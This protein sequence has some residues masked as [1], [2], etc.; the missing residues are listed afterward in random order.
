LCAW[1]DG[2]LV[3]GPFQPTSNFHKNYCTGCG[4]RTFYKISVDA[5]FLDGQVDRFFGVFVGDAYGKQYYFGISPWQFYFIGQHSNEGDSWDVIDAQWSGAVNA[6]Y[7]TNNFEVKVQPAFKQNTADYVFSLNGSVV[8]IIYAKPVVPS[9]T[10]LAMD[11]HAVTASYDNWT[12]E[13]IER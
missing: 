12:Y 3:M 8:Y 10:G 11:W 1:K 7:A 9:Q 2:A 4:A 13:E 6:S 5:T